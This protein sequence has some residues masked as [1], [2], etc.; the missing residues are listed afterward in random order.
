MF[1]LLQV[2]QP[3]KVD[4]EAYNGPVV[5]TE[6]P[7]PASGEPATNGVTPEK[8]VFHSRPQ[9]SS[10]GRNLQDSSFSFSG[11]YLKTLYGWCL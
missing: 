2:D 10:G 5:K 11:Q 9:T 3:Q 7:Q 8:N 6:A 1:L 4:R